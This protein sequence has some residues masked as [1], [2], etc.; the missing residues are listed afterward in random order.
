MIIITIEALHFGDGIIP[1]TF[2]AV[3]DALSILIQLLTG[4]IAA[5]LQSI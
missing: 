5:Y 1:V 3:K 4:N 2:F